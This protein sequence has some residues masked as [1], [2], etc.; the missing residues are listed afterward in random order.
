MT[1][2]RT[3]KAILGDGV[4]L[5]LKAPLTLTPSFHRGPLR[6]VW[7]YDI[8]K[9]DIFGIAHHEYQAWALFQ[10]DFWHAWDAFNRPPEELTE[11]QRAA[12][13]VLHTMVERVQEVESEPNCLYHRWTFRDSVR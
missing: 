1:E 4:I 13:E 10:H 11:K 5:H 6:D 2:S 9:L 7:I 3:T 12:K 8:S